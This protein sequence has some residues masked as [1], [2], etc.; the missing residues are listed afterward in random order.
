MEILETFL[1]VFCFPKSCINENGGNFFIIF[2][3]GTNLQWSIVRVNLIGSFT[4]YYLLIDN[5]C[6]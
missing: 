1:R 6:E 2:F 4:V 3:F 5:S